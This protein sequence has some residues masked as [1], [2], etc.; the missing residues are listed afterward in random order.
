MN[1]GSENQRWKIQDISDS[2]NLSSHH[3]PFF[4]LTET[5][6]KPS[7]FEAEVSIEN[8][9]A[10]RADR[11]DR[12]RGGSA[13]YLHNSLVADNSSSFSNSFCEVSLIYNKV[14]NTVLASLYRPPLAPFD[15]FS[16]CLHH[17]E[18]FISAVD[19]H[20]PEILLA[21]DFNFP[22]IDWDIANNPS[23]ASLSLS[24]RKSALSLLNFA[25][26]HLLQQIVR[27]PT[28]GGK[29]ILDLVFSNNSELIH[30]VSVSKT[31]KSDHDSVELFLLHPEFLLKPPVKPKF[32]PTSNF[33]DINFN[34]ANWESIRV[35]LLNV[36][37]NPIV[38][39][40]LSD[41][42]NAWRQFEDIIAGVCRKHAPLH[43][44]NVALS[45]KSKGIPRK[46]Q[47]L[48]RR[49]R[50][51]NIKINSIKCGLTPVTNKTKLARLQEERAK[52]ELSI[53]TELKDEREKEELDAL[54]KIKVNPKAFYSFARKNSSY[55]APIGPLLDES[56][57]LR[58][59][60]RDM[61]M[62]L[63]QQ[64]QKAFSDPYNGKGENFEER[65]P[66]TEERLL[67]VQVT[68]ADVLDAIA[69]LS[70]SSAP[71]PDKFPSVILAECKEIL[72][73]PISRMWQNSM[74]TGQIA[75]LFKLQCITPVF[76]KGSKATAA[77]YRPVSLTSHLIK[78]FEWVIRKQ[79]VSYIE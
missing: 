43:S 72:A 16:E 60:P 3:T 67:S 79:T 54:S 68:P 1:P 2:I 57:Q 6:L 18:T 52:V 35:D 66:I 5:H 51:L 47:L 19:S 26:E 50:R 11:I 29:N 34:S 25:D 32:R 41:Q 55:K 39:A 22:A 70:P 61:A 73:D 71:G 65:P 20:Y 40:S 38:S 42:D 49:K 78:I 31:L 77:N 14:S 7:I 17:I 74:D 30:S 36:D 12:I 62:I 48:L 44:T 75:D 63:Q 58:S 8:F 59:D 9:T 37:W 15:K 64:Y 76:K 10:Y 45:T 23:G 27:E 13:I 53:K 28:R 46:R 21:G 33:D 56:G 69:E 4:F 24:D